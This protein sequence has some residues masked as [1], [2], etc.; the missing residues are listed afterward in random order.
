MTGKRN[1]ILGLACCAFL[2]SASRSAVVEPDPAPAPKLTGRLR[3]MSAVRTAATSAESSAPGTRWGGGDSRRR[4]FQVAVEASY[5]E[6]K[7]SA[8]FLVTEASQANNVQG[9]DTPF[10]V[11]NRQ[12]EGVEFK[13]WGFIV[14]ILPTFDPA[15]PKAAQAQIQVE[16][17][18]PIKSSGVTLEGQEDRYRVP[19]I[20]TAQLQTEFFCA[21]GRKTLISQSPLRVEVTLSEAPGP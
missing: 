6:L 10:L 18:G 9:G 15:D 11:R 16:L 13:K 3:G 20:A 2:A 1:T 4:V 17:S 5:Q 19:E 21:L 7:G 14:N 8:A 12:G